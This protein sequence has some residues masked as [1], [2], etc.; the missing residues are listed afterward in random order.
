MLTQRVSALSWSATCGIES[1]RA[2]LAEMLRMTR[3][4]LARRMQSRLQS[5]R[6]TTARRS[7]LLET[8]CAYTSSL[9]PVPMTP[10]VGRRNDGPMTR[11]NPLLGLIVE[12]GSRRKSLC[13][14]KLYGACYLMG[15]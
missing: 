8:C 3:T 5:P 4:I 14:R 13:D 15:R 11:E 6:L 7:S 2:L 1:L 9:Q 10:C 12:T